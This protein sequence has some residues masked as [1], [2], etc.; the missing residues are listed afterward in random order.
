[1][2]NG[3]TSRKLYRAKN[4]KVAKKRGSYFSELGA[5]F[6]MAQGMLCVLRARDLFSDSVFHDSTKNFK[7]PWVEFILRGTP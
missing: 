2:F 4:A 6:D 5:P 7:I 3:T 1:M